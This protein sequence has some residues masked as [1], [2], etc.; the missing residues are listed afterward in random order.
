MDRGLEYIMEVA[1]TGSIARASQLLYITPSAL[2][3]FIQ[4]KERELGTP[5]FDRMGKRFVL[6]QAGEVYVRWGMQIA[7]MQQSMTEE[8]ERIAHAKAGRI[9][10]GF[11]M[12]LARTITSEI[13]PRY[14]QAFPDVEIILEEQTSLEL[15]RL[16]EENLIDFAIMAETEET[17]S[18]VYH[19][20]SDDQMVL[21]VPAGH[22]LIKEAVSVD[23][24]RYPWIDI[25]RFKEEPFVVLHQG[26]TLRKYAEQIFA[27]YKLSP[28]LPIQ[29]Q[30]VDTALRCVMNGLGVTITYDRLIFEADYMD[31]IVPL[32]FEKEPISRKLCLVNHKCHELTPAMENLMSVCRQYYI[33][34]SEFN[35]KK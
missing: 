10:L 35:R 6:T 4:S 17:E 20:L 14:K 23:G 2:S 7:Q 13:I 22:P 15:E 34:T 16:L 19:P 8:I 31:Q 9:R 12:I 3:K 26:K 27:K 5:L 1:R 33:H 30:M 11:P 21:A 28:Y 24:L 29:V 18:L 25:C 32:C